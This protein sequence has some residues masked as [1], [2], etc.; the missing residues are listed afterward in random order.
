LGREAKKRRK[1]AVPVRNA[2]LAPACKNYRQE[3]GS[4]PMELKRN[5]VYQDDRELWG[6]LE[7]Y[8]LTGL[9]IVR[10]DEGYA[11]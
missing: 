5:K 11:V 4:L 7:T 3:Q 8:D 10:N 2:V 9:E 6:D 1:I